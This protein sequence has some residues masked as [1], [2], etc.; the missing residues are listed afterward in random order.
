MMEG[1][2]LPPQWEWST[3]VEVSET[4]FGQSP[5][6]SSYNQ[7]GNGLPFFQGKAEFGA[8]HPT[9]AKW[10]TEPTR[11]A[12]AGDILMSVRAPVGPTNIAKEH[13]AIGRG[14]AAIRPSI[15][16]GFVE[17][18]FKL[19]EQ[20]LAAQGTGTTFSAITKKVLNGHPI[21]IAPLPEQQRIVE[22][23]ETLFAELDKGDD[24]LREVQKLL[25]RYRQSV[26]KA[27]VT[28]TLTADWRAANGAPQESGKDLLARILK[29]RRETWQGRGK[30]KESVEPDTEGLPELPEGWVW[31]SLSQLTHIK[32][33]VTVDKKREAADPVTLPYLRVANVQ[34]GFLDLGEIKEI[35]VDRSKADACLLQPMDILLNEGGDRDKLGRGW[36]WSGEIDPCIH[37]NHVY[38]ARPVVSEL[39]SHFVSYYANAFG[40]PFF[41]AKGTQS[42]NL[43][44]ISLTAIS[45]LPIPLPPLDE[46]QELVAII[47]EKVAQIENG[48]RA[49][50][51]ELVRAKAL[52]RSILKEAF[53]GKLVPHDPSDEPAEKL[54]ERI[55]AA[56]AAASKE[57]R[58]KAK[59]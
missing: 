23:I 31:A 12:K 25:A 13:C 36:V 35:T 7:E 54:L 22:K 33:G 18:W 3:I 44:S 4:I 19:T 28:G 9:V 30:Y 15:D 24:A 55:R 5:P 14:L 38:R 56:R 40:Q 26:L 17:Y 57:K 53:A 27:A 42:V 39:S 46:Q 16:C 48:L 51:T 32:G 37:Q 10:C 8:R 21:P 50:E 11:E 52:R 58:R 47:E 29:T 43:A 49:C 41:M 2:E 59:A 34:N 20:N 45:G 6:S 1:D